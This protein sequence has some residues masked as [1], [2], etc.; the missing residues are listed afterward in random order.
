MTLEPT[1]DDLLTSDS[2][3][4]FLKGFGAPAFSMRRRDW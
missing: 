2:A 4:C 3:E 1:N